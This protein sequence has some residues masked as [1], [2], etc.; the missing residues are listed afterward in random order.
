MA[1][2]RWDRFPLVDGTPPA[3][4]WL[5][6]QADLGLAETTIDA[7]GRALEDYLRFSERMVFSPDQATRAH[8][9]SYVRDLTTRPSQRG[10]AVRT[11]DSGARLANATMQQRVTAVR[12]FY[13]YLIEEGVRV[14]NPVGRGRYTPGKGFGGA[15]DRGLIPRYR[16]LP[17]I[18]SDA[19][20]RT[21][22]A[23]ARHEPLRNRL[24]LALAYDAALRREELCSLRTD[25]LDPSQRTL[26]V[27]AECTKGRNERVVPYSA[28][29]GAL[30]L[31]FLAERR[32]LSRARGPLFLSVSD[33]NRAQPIT[34][35]TW[36]KVVR[37]I[38]LRA[39]VPRF[40]THTLRH[41]CLTDLAR[42]GWELHTI[43]TFAGH[44][45]PTTTLQY[46][47]LAG[48]DLATRLERGMAQI[49][50]WRVET[51][52][53]RGVPEVELTP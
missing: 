22:L 30:L 15:R 17:W 11:L 5:Q 52:T 23:V 19:Q 49:H 37:A 9:A 48:R 35:W 36:S 38:A 13:D 44:R 25:D 41:L 34:L 21:L 47:H 53:R 45:N 14:D 18:P 40:S 20:W 8:I 16:K 7:Y 31:A 1:G 2:V 3:R 50:A 12:L 39:D 33:R 6:I 46:I 29:T 27:R 32:E 26:R 24:M 51:L 10:A 43:A 42:A 4:T 28:V